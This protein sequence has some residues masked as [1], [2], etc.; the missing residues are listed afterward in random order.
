ML[1]KLIAQNL[2]FM[3]INIKEKV[4]RKKKRKLKKRKLERNQKTQ[5]ALIMTS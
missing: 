4:K 2:Y 3:E 1:K 5:S